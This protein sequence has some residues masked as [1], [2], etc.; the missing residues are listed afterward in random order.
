MSSFDW[1][2]IWFDLLKLAS[3]TLNTVKLFFELLVQEKR[4]AT[5]VTN[6][7]ELPVNFDMPDIIVVVSGKTKK[8]RVW[9]VFIG[10]RETCIE[11]PRLFL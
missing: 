3:S 7:K 11:G 1:L 8:V 9:Y 10:F 2:I 5:A 6:R 4:N